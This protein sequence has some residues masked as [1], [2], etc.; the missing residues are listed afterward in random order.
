MRKKTIIHPSDI[1]DEDLNQVAHEKANAMSEANFH[2]PPRRKNNLSDKE[3]DNLIFT[4]NKDPMCAK[5]KKQLDQ[6]ENYHISMMQTV[7]SLTCVISRLSD[8]VQNLLHENLRV[9]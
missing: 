8:Q 7:A 9:S 4:S 2:T 3:D 6:Q 5:L 1:I